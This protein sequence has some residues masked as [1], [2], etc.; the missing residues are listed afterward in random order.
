MENPLE[1]AK[2]AAATQKGTQ[3]GEFTNFATFY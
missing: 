1:C 2:V 3:L